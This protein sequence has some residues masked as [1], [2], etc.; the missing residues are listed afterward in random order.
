WGWLA[1]AQGRYYMTFEVSGAQL[2]P[3]E[4]L[5]PGS[6]VSL[7]TM[8]GA[9]RTFTVAEVGAAKYVAANGELPFRLVPDGFYRFVDLADGE[10]NFATIDYGEPGDE[11]TLYTGK[12]LTLADLQ[13]S[14]G[15][16][17]PPRDETIKS[18]RLA[19]PNCNAPIELHS[20][21]TLRAACG[22]CSHLLDVQSGTL[23][24]LEQLRK[25]APRIPLGT[26]A[27]FSEGE[28]LVIG[29]VER[30]AQVEGEWYLF[31]EYLLYEPAI[32]FRWLVNSDGHWS[33]VQPVA[34]GAVELAGTGAKYDGVK[35]RLFQGAQLRVNTVVGEFY[36]QVK[37][38]E[39]VWGDDYVAPPAMLSKESSTGEENWSLSSYL[40]PSELKVALGNKPEFDFG[41]GTGVAPNQPN[42]A[43]AAAT[44]LTLGFVA[45]LVLGIVFSA[46]AP[47]TEKYTQVANIPAGTPVPPAETEPVSDVNPP[48]VFFSEPFQLEADKNVELGFRASLANNWAYVVAS[49]VN[50]ASGDV[51]T[52]DASMEHYAGVD[53]GESWSEGKDYD[54]EVIGPLAAG[55]YV[56]RLEMQHGASSGEVP[57]TVRVRQG[58]FRARYLGW[59]MVV[60]GIPF[61]LLGV[62]TYSFERRRWSNSTQGAS[63]M[64]KT[65]LVIV[66]G[67]VALLLAGIVAIIKAIAE[68]SGDD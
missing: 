36:W 10:G 61:L 51:A 30:S 25:A 28:M 33:Y 45:L 65:P 6:T 63:S 5:T 54:T 46:L 50:V 53:D 49:L 57:L 38:G 48:N 27:T 41:N 64:P 13:I 15:E 7:P 26:K 35:F 4:S 8:L 24:V 31:E 37:A 42:R 34:V 55:Q 14:G 58:V 40:K 56:L 23:H 62:Y 59:A 29:Y 47:A 1:E 22:Y 20:P 66:I 3:L 39:Q 52:V 68:S 44:P 2:P 12:Q 9:A 16:V 17:G 32:G 11:P 19:C 67:G 60:L 18:T 21:D 43:G